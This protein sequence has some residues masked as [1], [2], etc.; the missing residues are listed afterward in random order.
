MTSNILNWAAATSLVQSAQSILIVTHVSPDGDAIGSLLGLGNALEQMGKAVTCAVDGGLPSF[1]GF[2]PGSGTILKEL[3]NAR[4]DLM[5]TVDAGD[6]GRTGDVGAA[7]KEQSKHL[8]NLDHHTTNT[9]F[10]E[11]NLVDPEAVSAT[12]VIY[13]W[14]QQIGYELNKQIATPLLTGLVTD[15]LGFRT[16]NTTAETL[17]IAQ[18]LMQAGASLTEITERALDNRSYLVI[19]V[20]KHGLASAELHE[21]GVLIAQLPYNAFKEVGLIDGSDAGLVQFLI[22]VN[23]AMIAA[24]LKETAEGEIKLSIR[25]KP[26]FDVSNVAFGLG[27]GGHKQACGATIAGPLEEA[28]ARVLPLLKEAAKKGQLIIA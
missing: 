27:G 7:G 28:K 18:Q 13:Q 12:Q 20:W 1:M 19:N 23:E 8:I 15:T 4:W 3:P 16:S 2:L 24:V 5:I 26:G 6:E 14:L 25:S 21:G 10:G 17:Q 22:K 11:V 9:Q